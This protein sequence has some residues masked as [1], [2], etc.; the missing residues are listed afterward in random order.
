MTSPPA[1]G[2]YGGNY[3]VNYGGRF[4]DVDGYGLSYGTGYPGED[5]EQFKWGWEP[6][7]LDVMDCTLAYNR[8]ARSAE[9]LI[10]DPN[11]TVPDEYP[12]ATPVELHVKRS[13]D[14]SYHRR[15]GGFVQTP[16]SRQNT[17]VLKIASHDAWIRARDVYRSFSGTAKSDILQELITDLTPLRWDPDRVSVFDDEPIDVNY[18]GRPLDKV[19]EEIASASANEIFGA[20]DERYFFFEQRDAT[21]APRDFVVGEYFADSTEFEK[22]GSTELNQVTVNYGGEPAD[23]AVTVEDAEAQKTT[24][25]RLGSAD[26]VVTSDSKTFTD[27]Y[28]EDAAR[29]KAEEILSG[30][31]AI[32]TGD[33]TTWE[34]FDV[35]P[36]QLTTV[37]VPEQ[38]IDGEYRVAEISHSWQDDETQV[39]LA[40][41]SDGVV[42]T[43]VEL[44]DEISRL[45]ARPASNNPT[46]T[47]FAT[48]DL[49]FEIALSVSAFKRTVPDDQLL[50]GES[51]G[52]WGDPRSG[53]GRWGDQ[54]GD[55]QQI[56]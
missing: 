1:P 29:R 35:Q 24:G 46:I 23:Q 20:T 50:F 47:R 26:S 22:D 51:R 45:E 38:D 53:G 42:D 30:A 43:L 8:F 5:G 7:L 54:R 52:G 21:R 11:G 9:V 49:P 3:G 6:R 32:T 10:D 12:R 15:F 13:V 16:K 56:L 34:A 55:R 14:D 33:L 48:F 39:R 27:I 28:S 31:T 17:T 36:G 4:E 25:D 40:E 37:T 19:V 2:G 18:S 44:S 41:N